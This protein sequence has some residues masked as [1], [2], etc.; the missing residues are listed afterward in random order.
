ME[1]EIR[2][3]AEDQKRLARERLEKEEMRH[4][5]NKQM[6][7]K[8]AREATAKAH[9]DEQAILW[10]RDKQNY[11]NEENRLAQKIKMIN[12]ENA[13]FLKS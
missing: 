8:N 6:I 13:S 10:A 4:L 9:N 1:R 12:V 11:E 3:R 7:E 5:L 2:L